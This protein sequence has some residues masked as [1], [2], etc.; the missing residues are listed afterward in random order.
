MFYRLITFSNVGKLAVMILIM[1]VSTMAFKVEYVGSIS[2]SLCA[3]TDLEITDETISV[4]EPFNKQ[5]KVYSAE[6]IFEYKINIEG[7][8]SGLLRLSEKIYLF[9]DN[10][11]H[12]VKAVDITNGTVN[13]Y[14]PATEKLINPVDLTQSGNVIYILDAGSSRVYSFNTQSQVMTSQAIRDSLGQPIIFASSFAYDDINGLFYILDQ[15]Q[16]RILIISRDGNYL[17]EFGSFGNNDGQITRGGALILGHDGNVYV[18]DRYQGRVLAFTTEGEFIGNI[19]LLDSDNGRMMIPTGLGIDTQRLL[20]V[21]STES[22]EIHIFRLPKITTQQQ[23]YQ[24]EQLLPEHEQTIEPGAVRFM[25]QVEVVGEPTL[26]TGLDFELYLKDIETPLITK[27]NI[28]PGAMSDIA[29]G[30]IVTDWEIDDEL[31]AD[32]TLFWR[33]RIRTG[34]S[35]EDWTSMHKFFTTSDKFLPTE[36]QL[37]Q[38]YPNPFN[39]STM[40]SFSLPIRSEVVLTVYNVLGQQVRK[41]LNSTMEAG[42]HDIN[43]DS[44]D[45]NNQPVGS[46]IY[47]YRL[48]A[49]EFTKSRKMVLIR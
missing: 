1:A 14:L 37:G 32:T 4:L 29:H 21:A 15:V 30:L 40:I 23:V 24:T 31:P 13:S 20:Y 41:L 49:G 19:D 38:N 34:E 27:M 33:V 45:D 43:W 5:I 16:S 47:F 39:P 18:T 48:T 2:D 42:Q 8:A 7:N 36:F 26:V 11:A 12:E 6:G 9:C 22:A 28:P 17:G 44:R 25:V 3:P 46:G 10:R 35:A